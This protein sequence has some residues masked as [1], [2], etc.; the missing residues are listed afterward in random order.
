MINCIKFDLLKKK[1][2]VNLH[3]IIIILMQ[4]LIKILFSE[5]KKFD[6][7]EKFNAV[8]KIVIHEIFSKTDQIS[9]KITSFRPKKILFFSNI[10]EFNIIEKKRICIFIKQYA[11]AITTKNFEKNIF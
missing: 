9:L 11:N 7:T 4:H 5:K 10:K 8:S 3:L 6:N 1:K 2:M